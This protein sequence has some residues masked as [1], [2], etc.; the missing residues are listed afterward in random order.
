M[1]T[2]KNYLSTSK[3]SKEK[4]VSATLYSTAAFVTGL[5]VAERALGFLYRIVLS[6]LIG[7]EALGIYQVALSVFAV[8]LTLGT[9]GIPITVS[10]LITKGRAENNAQ[11][12][13]RAVGAGI[14]LSL[15]LTAP[16]CLLLTLKNF[17]LGFLFSDER[18]LPVFRILL[19]GL[20]FSS[21][22]AVMRGSFWGKK[23]FLAPS[24]MEIAEESVMVI[25]GI[26]LLQRIDNP[27]DGA[28]NA[29]W[30][31]VI[32]YLFSFSISFLYFFIRGGQIR[33]PKGSFKPLYQA[34]APITLVRTSGTLINSAV[35]V[36]LPVMLI[37]AG[38]SQSQ[39]LSD[40]GVMSGMVLPVLMIPATVIGAVSLVLSPE[41]S[42][43]FFRKNHTRI[44]QNLA[45]GIWTALLLSA[46]LL[47]FFYALGNELGLLAFSSVLAGQMIEK[48]CVLLLPMSISMI[49][50][51]MLNALG[52]EKQTFVVYFISAAALLACIF[53]LPAVCGIYAYLIGMIANFTVCCICNLF[54][55]HKHFRGF[56]KQFGRRLSWTFLRALFA[57]LPLS[58]F[59]RLVSVLMQKTFGAVLSMFLTGLVLAAASLFAWIIL[60][61]ISGKA[62]K[63][64]FLSPLRKR[65][66]KG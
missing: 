4:H 45:R 20:V 47:P 29:A 37:R 3:K 57:V 59:G 21:L 13:G 43:D 64:R 46:F 28:K 44:F 65:R 41:L 5:S 14:A 9:G 54:L 36:L 35:S 31:A 60:Q 55:L 66:R 63:E 53:F 17:R 11:A 51:S 58:L 49:T 6:R 39:A 18:C 23:Q 56:Y 16:V 15:L 48:G 24:V 61:I 22:Y 32:S 27:L 12:E 52:K 62:I 42:E 30:A 1:N 38:A 10:R 50:T 8:F 33:A 40:F 26:L 19:L 34:V 2:N 7:A 25:A